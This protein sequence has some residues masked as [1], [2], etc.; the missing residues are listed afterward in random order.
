M[1]CQAAVQSST[2]VPGSAAPTVPPAANK[3]ATAA[4][5]ATPRRVLLPKA[6]ALYVNIVLLGHSRT[7]VLVGLIVWVRTPLLRM[8]N[9]GIR[10][11]GREKRPCRDGS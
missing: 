6:R 2:A 7:L 11:P 5:R 9:P 1:L 3:P 8:R 10:P 4:I